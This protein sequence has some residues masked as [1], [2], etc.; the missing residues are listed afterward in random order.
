MDAKVVAAKIADWEAKR[1]ALIQKAE[2][3]RRDLRLLSAN[4]QRVEGAI[5]GAEE[6]LA[7]IA[8]V[9]GVQEKAPDPPPSA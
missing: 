7:S 4:I 8:D 6:L 3:V 9:K 2:E 5:S 1:T